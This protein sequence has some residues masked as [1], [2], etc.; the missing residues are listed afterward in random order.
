M[1][2][3]KYS[4][5]LVLGFPLSLPIVAYAVNIG[6]TYV[7]T[8]QNQP[9][10]ASINVS[11]VNPRTF[12]VKVAQADVY[13]QLGLS[14]DADIQIKFVPTSSN[15]GQI[16]LTTKRAINAPFTDVVLNITE[17]GVTKTLP[18][19]LLMPIDSAQK[20]TTQANT[21]ALQ[22]PTQNIVIGSANPVQL[23][24]LSPDPM[25]MQ[26]ITLPSTT[27]NQLPNLPTTGMPAGAVPM[28]LASENSDYLRIQE[29]RTVRTVQPN[30]TVYTQAMPQTQNPIQ[31]NDTDNQL[32]SPAAGYGNQPLDK[33]K[34]K[35]KS[36]YSAKNPQIIGETIT[37]TLQRNDNL[38][39][40]ASNIA[41]AN[42]KDVD[43][44][45][46][47]IMAANPTAFP[48]N[49]PSKLVANTQLQIPKYKVV[50]SQIGI[51]SANK[52]RQQ[53][54]QNKRRVAG[55]KSVIAPK[56]AAKQPATPK[57]TKKTL[58][59]QKTPRP[60]A[61]TKKSE[62]TIIAPNHSNGSVQGQSTKNKV[63]KGMSSQVAAQVQQKRQA[64]AQQ[65]TKVNKLN[66]DLV[67]AENR[68]KIQNTKLAQLEKRLKELNKK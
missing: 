35:S 16:V 32:P 2:W 58:K 1:S 34:S 22:S 23:P 18:K 38:W 10:N 27:I 4:V 66:Q 60:Y 62:M 53:Y 28:T 33:S 25:P 50:P 36:K 51:K 15:G 65:A 6:D 3:Q 37:Y 31:T 12:S 19:T 44:V 56:S 24:V 11:D 59:A 47:D 29:T 20:I 48:D 9:L 40:I 42:R 43:Q 39:T 14:K 49:D 7:Q 8:Q 21:T 52:A 45:M 41:A 67:G 5:H 26:P 30:G 63:G 61:A 55:K 13:R 68:L 54:R 57:T 64:T 17:N 46:A